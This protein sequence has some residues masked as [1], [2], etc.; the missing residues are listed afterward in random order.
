MRKKELEAKVKELEQTV[1][2]MTARI[3]VYEGNTETVRADLD[4]SSL[5]FCGR[6]QVL[7]SHETPTRK[8]LNRLLDYLNLEVKTEP[9]EPERTVLRK[10]A[11]GKT[12]E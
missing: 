1:L 11:K 8:I 12:G 4:M 2:E 7:F 5:S 3:D 10:K 6:P 9:F